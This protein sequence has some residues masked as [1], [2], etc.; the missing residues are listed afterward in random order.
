MILIT[1][2]L[3]NIPD[4]V[5]ESALIDGTNAWQRFFHIKVQIIKPSLFA[6]LALIFIQTF[7]NFDLVFTITGGGPVKSTELMTTFAYR[8]T[9]S[10]GQYGQGAAITLVLFV[11][12]MVMGFLYI[13]LIK[14]DEVM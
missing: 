5:I 11:I 14:K 9:F 1:A 7:K 10:E 2:A 8:L 3:V 6:T 13:K 12:L 4:A